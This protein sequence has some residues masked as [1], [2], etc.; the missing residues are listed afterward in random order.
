ME[1]DRRITGSL[2]FLI[3][4]RVGLVCANMSTCFFELLEKRR[5]DERRTDM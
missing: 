3:E 4:S 1:P 5:Y 2:G